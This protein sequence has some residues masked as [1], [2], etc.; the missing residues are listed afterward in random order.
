MSAN[1]NFLLNMLSI[2]SHAIFAWL[3]RDVKQVNRRL[4]SIWSMSLRSVDD[5]LKI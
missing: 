2:A 3:L 1:Q 5:L 4:N